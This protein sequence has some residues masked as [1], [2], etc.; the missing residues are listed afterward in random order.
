MTSLIGRSQKI[1]HTGSRAVIG[2]LTVTALV[3]VAVVKLTPAHSFKYL[4]VP[5]GTKGAVSA[6]D[7]DPFA[8]A[9]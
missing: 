3:D 9:H 6:D 1:L 5:G 4:I 2:D 7:V 8:I